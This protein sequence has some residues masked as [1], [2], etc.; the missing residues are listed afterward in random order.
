[1]N[2][3]PLMVGILGSSTQSDLAEVTSAAG[4]ELLT[5]ALDP[6]PNVIL[7]SSTCTIKA[8]TEMEAFALVVEDLKVVAS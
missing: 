1:M 6:Q 3:T 8:I 5:W 2:L 7:P 4:E